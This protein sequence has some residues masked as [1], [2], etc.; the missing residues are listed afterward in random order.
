MRAII[1]IAGAATPVVLGFLVLL[2]A[3]RV[4]AAG[5]CAPDAGSGV[6]EYAQMTERL[7]LRTLSSLNLGVTEVMV[8]PGYH[9]WSITGWLLSRP[10]SGES[11]LVGLPPPKVKALAKDRK[12]SLWATAGCRCSGM[13]PSG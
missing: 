4:T 11:E 8:H 1:N 7:L 13:E 10:Y 2:Q 3:Q 12:L 5:R 6:P 9:D